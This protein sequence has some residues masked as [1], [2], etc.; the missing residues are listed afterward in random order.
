M[1]VF[2]QKHEEGFDLSDTHFSWMVLSTL[3]RA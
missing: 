2:R 3:S 1:L